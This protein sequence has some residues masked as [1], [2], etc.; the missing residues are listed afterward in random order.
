MA[1][2]K[3]AG[4]TTKS[5]CFA[6]SPRLAWAMSEWEGFHYPPVEMRD[7]ERELYLTSIG[8]VAHPAGA[9][10]PFSG[11]PPEYQFRWETGRILSDFAV[12]WIEKGEGEV[13]TAN[14]GRAA[15]LPDQA[16]V[17]PPGVW[18]R[19]RSNP[20]TG[21]TEKWLCFNGTFLHRLR[22]KGVFPSTP[23]LRPIRDRAALD[24]AFQRMLPGSERNS[25]LTAGHALTLLA[26]IM[27]E[28]DSGN[29]GA[30]GGVSSGNSSVD[31][32]V[33]FIWANCHRNLNVEAIAQRLGLSRR[34]L[35]RRFAEAWPRGVAQE[36]EAA[37]VQRGRDLLAERSLTVKEAG[38]AAGFGGARRFIE[39][40]RRIHGTTPGAARQDQ[41]GNIDGSMP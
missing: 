5:P 1:T 6:A 4:I 39:A 20:A 14:L 9:E 35:E 26:L 31:A 40:H 24:E 13:E 33:H 10:Y 25:L 34:M 11:N 28:T 29:R 22:T 8:R 32:A 2:F 12:V 30:G 18:H 21:W 16:L 36:I 37:R 15:F 27:D 23:E 7:V 17:L 41:S 19:Y 3:H 38:Y